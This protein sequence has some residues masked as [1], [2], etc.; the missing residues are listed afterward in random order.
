MYDTWLD[1]LEGG[2]LAGVC[3]VDMSAAFDLVDN[4]IL[5]QKLKLYGFDENILQWTWSYLT[6][7]SQGVYIDGAMSSLQILEAGVPQGSILGPLYYTIFTNELPQVVHGDDCPL[8]QNPGP[9]IFAM[10]CEVCGGVCCYADDST[11]TVRGH[12]PRE[13]SEKLTEK[14]RVLADFLTD[15]KLDTLDCDDH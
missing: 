2:E 15:N 14:Y 9:R 7:R 11:F 4:E 8:K 3:M 6:Y 12:S 13:L 5:I 10:H 1:A